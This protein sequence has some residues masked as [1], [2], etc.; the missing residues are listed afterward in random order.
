MAAI[1]LLLPER[2]RLPGALPA[3][4]ARALGRADREQGEA[5]GRAQ[6]RR[7]F[8]LRPDRWPAAA[9][10][11]QFDAGDAAGALWL[12]ADP[13]HVAPDLNGAR[14][15]GWGEGLGVDAADTDALLPTLRPLFGDAGLQL[16][17]PHPARWY[18]RLP[19]A[20]R[21]PEFFA[22]EEAAG[23]DLFGVLP[24][25]DTMEARR[26]R[27]L[28]TEVQV[29]LHHHPWNRER[30]AQ[31]RPAINALWFWGGGTVPDEV[32][33]PYMNVRSRDPLLQA[34]AQ[35]SGA[36]I[37][38]PAAD[39]PAGVVGDSLVDLRHLRSLDTFAAQALPPL[40]RAMA[41]REYD[42]LLLDF[43]DGARFRLGHAQRWRFWR[44]PLATL[45]G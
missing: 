28:I 17:A 16:D 34:L 7:H 38:A 37:A 27:A 30:A 24:Q 23:E 11:R 9:L 39:A 29:L 45:A 2:A 40:L 26:W 8:R 33:G 15:L 22:P 31:G 1:A 21:L 35:A 18:L 6:L 14:L 3:A 43:E 20:V 42:A 32:R 25:G 41:R 13:A 44:P 4:A 10:T 12:R 36:A 19:E 5:G